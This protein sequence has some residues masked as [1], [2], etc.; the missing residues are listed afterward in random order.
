MRDEEAVAIYYQAISVT[1][2]EPT[3][4]GADM[5]CELLRDLNYEDAQQA[6]IHLLRR[7]TFAS[8]AEIR[9]EVERIRRD[10]WTRADPFIPS[11]PDLTPIEAAA[12]MRQYWRAVG[13]GHPP[14][15]VDRG[16]LVAGP[17][18]Q[19]IGRKIDE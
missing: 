19:L 18:L 9:S 13:D 6:L 5:W 11:S 10:R 17:Q 4:H 14:E 12:E 7:S 8:P 1:P 2:G 15:P 16:E 3:V